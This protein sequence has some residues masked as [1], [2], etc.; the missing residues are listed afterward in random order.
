MSPLLKKKTIVAKLCGVPIYD[1]QIEKKGAVTIIKPRISVEQYFFLQRMQPFRE[2][3]KKLAKQWDKEV[4]ESPLF[5]EEYKNT[6]W[7]H[8]N[9][10]EVNKMDTYWKYKDPITTIVRLITGEFK[11][12]ADIADKFY[13]AETNRRHTDQKF[14]NLR[15]TSVMGLMSKNKD[16][17]TEELFSDA[18]KYVFSLEK[19]GNLDDLRGFYE[20]YYKKLQKCI[21]DIF[22]PNIQN[23]PAK[24][25]VSEK[26]ANLIE[27]TEESFRWSRSRQDYL[28][29]LR[30]KEYD[31]YA[32]LVK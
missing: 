9:E 27:Q 5:P 12:Y 14:Y 3:E 10:R 1:N 16:K 19:F 25:M 31:Y 21:R 15:N 2:H 7:C 20:R 28:F 6:Y 17:F 13:W 30:M 24:N 29:Q 23:A 22:W 4:R 11:R 18:L 32:Q 8:Y 26:H